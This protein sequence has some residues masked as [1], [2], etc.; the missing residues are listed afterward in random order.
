MFNLVFC[1][2][3]HQEGHILFSVTRAFRGLRGGES[4]LVVQELCIGIH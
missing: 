3:D 1:R 2:M 4:T